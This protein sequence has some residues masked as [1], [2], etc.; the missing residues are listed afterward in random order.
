MG[1]N[2]KLKNVV[3]MYCDAHIWYRYGKLKTE[4]ATDF[5]SLSHLKPLLDMNKM[6]LSDIDIPFFLNCCKNKSNDRMDC[7]ELGSFICW[8]MD[9]GLY[10]GR[11]IKQLENA[12][13]AM[14]F[15]ALTS[16]QFVDMV[17]E[18]INC[19]FDIDN[20]IFI[21]DSDGNI[22]Y[23]FLTPP[24]LS[25]K[26]HIITDFLSYLDIESDSKINYV[27]KKLF[28]QYFFVESDCFHSD[29]TVY[30]DLTFEEGYKEYYK[31]LISSNQS[32]YSVRALQ[33]YVKFYRF[34]QD[35]QES[36]CSDNFRIYTVQ[37]MNYIY[38]V[39]RL[40]DG[41]KVINYDRYVSPPDYCKLLIKPMGL[42]MKAERADQLLKL[43][44]SEIQNKKLRRWFMECF[45]YDTTHVFHLRVKTY[46]PLLDYICFLESVH[47][48]K[49]DDD[50][51]IT[52]DDAMDFKRHV[53]FSLNISSQ[54]SY[55]K[56]ISIIRYFHQFLE[57]R[58]YCDELIKLSDY[59]INDTSLSKA[60]NSYKESYSV[61]E[62]AVLE[63][64]YDD[65]ADNYKD[66]K[67]YV[68]YLIYAYLF[69]ILVRCDIR[70]N[71]LLGVKVDAVKT[72]L[73]RQAKSEY[74]VM[75]ADKNSGT[76][77]V[78]HNIT[79]EVKGYFDKILELT[80]SYRLRAD[81]ETRSIMAIHDTGYHNSVVRYK[82]DGFADYHKRVCAT[83]GIK[84][85]K[86]SAVRNYYCQNFARKVDIDVDLDYKN[87]VESGTGHTL[88]VQINNYDE[89]S[90]Q[91]FCEI[92][93]KVGQIGD[94]KIKG[95]VVE[96]K[97]NE[98]YAPVMDGCG[99]CTLENCDNMSIL[100][101]LMCKNFIATIDNIDDF[102][103]A[104]YDI[105][106]KIDSENINH[107]K[108]LLNTK[109]KLYVAY[110]YRLYSLKEG[111]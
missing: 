62:I 25:D 91:D 43:D 76:E 81:E 45:W 75:S 28:L 105:D 40:C 53:V 56:Y 31:Y 14:V 24:N 90:L 69:K 39:R 50:I 59:F 74:V 85:A 33:L 106:K 18:Q 61:D 49:P 48:Y 94:V 99:Y 103:R 10:C 51:N 22:T 72:V 36:L 52:L 66:S 13:K 58:G 96:A 82:P 54:T 57:A 9:C 87:V 73:Q 108:E 41:Y 110:L 104:I 20:I 23:L 101:C 111:G 84:P 38:L 21:S 88:S 34:V 8:L 70:Y 71:N 78:A 80:S 19:G 37:V 79:S 42:D 92:A 7:V 63:R 44:I 1:Y 109:K 27:L 17:P 46:K 93:Y 11:D 86:L 95:Q 97:K 47:K 102:E 100:E 16:W 107:T 29:L 68:K 60:R 26:R 98:S 83:V 77:I 67:Q 15:R 35:R 55:Y 32:S 2:L 30:N 5:D 12:D 6:S 4:Y 65:Y 64:A 89:L 3:K